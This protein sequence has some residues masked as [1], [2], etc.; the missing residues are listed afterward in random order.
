MDPMDTLNLAESE[1]QVWQLAQIE[2][3]NDNP[4][5]IPLNLERRDFTG[6]RCFI[7]RSWKK[8]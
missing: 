4:S 1:A 3:T 8:P 5:R 7:D 2:V 6:F